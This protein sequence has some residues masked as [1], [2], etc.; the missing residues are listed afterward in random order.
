M[1]QDKRR[2]RKLKRDLKR[3]GSKS[4]RRQLKRDLED[5]PAEAHHSEVDLGRRSTES[6]N[7]IDNDATRRR[8]SDEEAG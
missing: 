1:D 8:G 2:H 5:N 3:A 6:M 7:G 4:R